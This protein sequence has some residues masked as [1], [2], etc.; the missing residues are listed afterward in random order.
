MIESVEFKN[1]KALQ[2]TT[3]PLSPFTLIVS[4]NGSGKTTALKAISSA[5]NQQKI[6]YSTTCSLGHKLD[7]KMVLVHLLV[8]CV[9]G[10]K[11]KQLLNL[12]C[13]SFF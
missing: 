8:T 1:Y 7:M 12:F 10:N 5:T 3:L 9:G 2:N 13:K 4:A 11:I 6:N